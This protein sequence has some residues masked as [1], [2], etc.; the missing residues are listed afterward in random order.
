M[1]SKMGFP[2]I[3]A[4][5]TQCGGSFGSKNYTPHCMFYAAALARKTGRAVKFYFTKEEHFGVFVL[6]LGSRF[7]GK[8]GIKKDGT[9]TAVQGDWLVDTGASSDMAQ[10]QIAVGC[11]EVQLMLQCQNW[12][13]KTKLICTHRCPSGVI[14]GF[15][16]QELESSLAPILAQ[17][18][19]KADI[20]PLDF[21]KKNY[22]KPGEDFVWRE[23]KT[24]ICRGKDYSK[25]MQ[26]GAQAF[27][28][29]KKWKGWLKPTV[30]DG[31]LRV[32]VGLGVHGNADVGEDDSEA[33]VRLNPDATA[34]IHVC[35]AESG[36]GQRSNLCKMVAEVLGLP[37][38]NVTMTPP[39]TLVNPFD[40]GLVGSRGTYAV[41][42]GV[43]EAAEEALAK[44]IAKAA[45]RLKVDPATLTT[46]D[47]Q[48]F[49][50]ENPNRPLRWGRILGPMETV[51][52]FGH[53]HP[54]HSVPNF[55]I[56]FVEVI[57]DTETGVVK[58]TKVVSASDVG[59]VIDPA[60]MDAQ[61]YG[62]LGSAGLDSALFEETVI[63]RKNGRI[64]NMNMV[65]YKWR[66]FNE[67][68]NMQNVI[69][70]TP[71]PT[72]SFQAIGLGEV[73]TSPGPAA[74]QMAVSNAIGRHLETYPLTPEVILKALGQAER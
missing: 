25:A 16:G 23:G 58:V 44:L 70:E 6:R 46:R 4:I 12:D 19:S 37:L 43:I 8:I 45:H 7:R 53:F 51:T 63:D 5:T 40:F 27:D 64:L 41:G 13:L 65:D 54:D 73:A 67:L 60:A 32:G 20:N 30:V 71:F 3:R 56:Q 47:G 38:T 29:E 17:V 74:V 15:G 55:I 61:L 49:S 69:L 50:E 18:M 34:T 14:R 59:Q 2:D 9:V 39:D 62:A 21:F 72:R 66:T 52:G 35:V 68:P 31:P 24:W 42:S 48:I 10:A 22:I 26:K 57:V 33:Y 36:M 11:G 28:W 1:Q